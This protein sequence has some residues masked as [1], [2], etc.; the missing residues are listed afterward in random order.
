MLEQ[1]RGLN[2]AKI[3]FQ[4]SF[5]PAFSSLSLENL[6]KASTNNMKKFKKMSKAK[7]RSCVTLTVILVPILHRNGRGSYSDL[8]GEKGL[9][10]SKVYLL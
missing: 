7:R 4:L 1:N 9:S 2:E 10:N 3:A 8:D 5:G 6:G